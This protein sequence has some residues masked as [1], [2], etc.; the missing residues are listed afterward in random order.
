MNIQRVKMILSRI[1]LIGICLWLCV[2]SPFAQA[3]EKRL[4][5]ADDVYRLQ[6]ITDPQVSPEGRWIAYTVTG[7]DREADKL[8]SAVWMVDWEGAQNLQVTFG[9]DTDTTPRWS[10]DGKYLA[11]LSARP[12]EGKAQ[13]WLLDRRG[14]EARRLT[15]V[16]GDISDYE[17]SP[18]GKRLALVMR[19]GDDDPGEAQ[20]SKAKAPKPIV[21]ERYFFKRDVDGY[22][23]ASSRDHLYL[24]DVESKKLEALTGEK[25]FD[26]SD[27]AWSPD[28][29]QLAFISNHAEDPDRTGTRDIFIIEARAGAVPRKLLTVYSP[30]RQRLVWSPDGRTLAFI[31][32]FEPK[33]YAYSQE[34]LAVVPAA[35]GEPRV[36]T[37]ALDRGVTQA[38]FTLDGSALTFLVEDDQRTYLAKVA[39]GGGNVERVNESGAVL[40][41]ISSGGGHTAVT[42]ATDT[43]ATEIYALE[44]GKLRKLTVHNDALLAELRLGAV[45][46]MSFRSK[47]GTE[48]H[49]MMVKPPS[50]EEGKTYPTLLWIHGGPNMQDDHALTFGLYPLQLERQFFA[51]HG[52]VVLAINYRGGSGRGAEFT[53]SIFADWGNKEVADLLAGVDDAVRKGVADPDRLGLGG[54]SYG[55]ILTNYTIAT[56]PRFKAAV[57]GA[58][59]SN[60]ISMYGGDEYVLQYDNE[61]GPPWRNPEAWVNV[62]YAFFHADRIHTPTLFMGGEKD[63]NVPIIGGEQMYQALRTLGVPTQLVVYPGQYHL[64]TRPSYIHDRLGRYLAWFDAYVKTPK[65]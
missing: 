14:G 5:A 58:G 55:G 45:E 4:L 12:A 1:V 27:P 53:K 41:E 7:M 30:D 9:P 64:L 62:S 6:E 38:E 19:D 11:F 59:S 49:G 8:R 16:K 13:I 32:G 46:D 39:V 2:A 40:S 50:Y 63:F 65:K 21:I 48:I 57:S 56:D 24:F 15:S 51:A 44:N 52:Y 42:A 33:Y 29:A 36:L 17:W 26:E 20:D 23:T 61:L 60:Q 37:A 43:S 18:D 3:P 34:R 47:D 10:P 22:L 54:W 31:Q 35:G 28:G 25:N